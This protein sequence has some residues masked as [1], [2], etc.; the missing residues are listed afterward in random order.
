MSEAMLMV[1]KG[2]EMVAAGLRQMAEA[3]VEIP[4]LSVPTEKAEAAPAPK[5]EE[6]K[7]TQDE[8]RLVLAEKSRAGKTQEVKMLLK[9]CGAD[10]LSA[11]PEEKY[12]ELLK[13]AEAL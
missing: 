2:C 11:V 4:E 1:A 10:K 9:E 7:I 8:V 5:T 3:G 12:E 6:K 13:K